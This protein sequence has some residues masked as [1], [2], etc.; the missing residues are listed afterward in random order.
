MEI[1][2]LFG[3]LLHL[4]K[5]FG[6]K[7]SK[8]HLPGVTDSK[9]HCAL[10]VAKIHKISFLSYCLVY[11]LSVGT[12]F[13]LIQ[14]ILK[15]PFF[16]CLMWNCPISYTTKSHILQNHIQYTTSLYNILQILSNILLYIN[17]FHKYITHAHPH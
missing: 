12:I 14:W 11:Q 10:N 9:P 4:F 15:L 3:I 16:S 13:T 5:V 6:Q 8:Y 2:I 1:D 7:S 17:C